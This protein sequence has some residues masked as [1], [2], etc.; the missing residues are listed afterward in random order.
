MF[1]LTSFPSWATWGATRAILIILTC[2]DTVL[3]ITLKALRVCHR[4]LHVS[5]GSFTHCSASEIPIGYQW[6]TYRPWILLGPPLRQF[7]SS[8]LFLIIKDES[9][10]GG[11]NPARPSSLFKSWKMSISIFPMNDMSWKLLKFF[12]EMA[13]KFKAIGDKW[14]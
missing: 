1:A 4:L 12:L 11:Q 7:K 10:S 3:F 5:Q 6:L 13:V 8:L 9:Q 14:Q 2:R